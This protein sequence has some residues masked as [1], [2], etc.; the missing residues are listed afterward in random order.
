MISMRIFQ[1]ARDHLGER[2][3]RA[4]ALRGF[5]EAAYLSA[6][7]DVAAAVAAGVISSGRNHY[8]RFGRYEGRRLSR[9]MLYQLVDLPVNSVIAEIDS[10]GFTG[11]Y[12]IIRNKELIPLSS[13]EAME[14]SWK[15][16]VFNA[17]KVRLI[18]LRNVFVAG[19]GIVLEES[20]RI[21]KDIL[22]QQSHEQVHNAALM[23]DR[24]IMEG[25]FPRVRGRAVLAVKPGWHNYFHFLA[26]ILPMCGISKSTL[27]SEGYKRT[28]FLMS[29]VS[30]QKMEEVKLR[31]TSLL[32]IAAEEII[33]YGMVPTFVEELIVVLGLTEH[34]VY[35][36]PLIF[37]YIDR[38][39][40]NIE[41]APFEKLFVKRGSVGHRNFVN[42]AAVDKIMEAR[43]YK[44]IAPEA[45][46]FDDQV[47]LFKGARTILGMAGA[48]MTNMCF[49][50]PGSRVGIF[51]P[52]SM[53]DT[54][55]WFIAQHKNQ[56]LFDIRCRGSGPSK[57]H[58]PWDTDLE[59]G[60]EELADV[61][62]EMERIP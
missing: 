42:A 11:R 40:M 22:T 5:D 6:N 20:R 61:F 2:L 3:S 19:E 13:L 18:R 41:P 48:A 21:Y 55:F 43:G 9:D 25:N 53:A 14:V 30:S 38:L 26:E 52:D 59:I 31:T 39:G 8:L 49:S 10:P 58:M 27:V 24:A 62:A 60:T 51:Y 33:P 50:T 37:N 34:G 54:S 45:Y 16:E 7:P 29:G 32:D 28:Q 1:K 57:T 15:R 4:F 23:V 17:R 36:S 56:E 12:P 46:S 44:V 47:A 35:M